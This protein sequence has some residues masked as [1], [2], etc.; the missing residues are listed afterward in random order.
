MTQQLASN[1][2][3][4]LQRVCRLLILV[5][6]ISRPSTATDY[7]QSVTNQVLLY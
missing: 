1:S 2:R 6:A 3:W 4:I 7:L 5:Q